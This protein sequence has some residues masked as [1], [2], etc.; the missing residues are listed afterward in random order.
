MKTTQAAIGKWRGILKH[1]GLP[2]ETLRNIHQPCPLCGGSDRYRFDDKDGTGSYFCSGCGAGDGLMLLMKYTGMDFKT[3]AKKVDEI[4][5]NINQERV[6]PVI[7]GGERVSRILSGCQV[8]TKHDAA[9][10]YLASR[11]LPAS[12]MLMFNPSVSYFEDGKFVANY[13]A[14]IAVMNNSSG[15]V[16]MLH[17]THLNNDGTKADVKSVK[18]YTGSIAI[19]DGAHIRLTSVQERIGIA[20]GIETALAV[21][22]IYRI[23]CWASGSA[24]FMETFKAPKGVKF[25]TVFADND[26]NY[27][28]Q[29][30]AYTLANR[31][32]T[33]QSLI[34]VVEVP[35]TEGDYA[36]I[37]K[38]QLGETA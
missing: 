9:G 35:E 16:C 7:N 29:A 33:S 22:K 23:P 6:K 30:A 14:M 2:E 18:K 5:G 24:N 17:I 11:G 26:S 25:V 31:L 27:R 20:E 3:A 10:R 36:D 21:M 13:P 4:V 28:G 15:D 38:Q 37:L 19:T 8:I 34:S 1:F 12:K 32:V